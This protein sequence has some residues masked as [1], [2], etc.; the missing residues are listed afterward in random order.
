MVRELTLVEK[1]IAEAESSGASGQVEE[2][3][4][5]RATLLE[6]IGSS[7]YSTQTLKQLKNQLSALQSQLKAVEEQRNRRIGEYEQKKHLN[8]QTL[9][10]A[11]NNLGA[12]NKRLALYEQQVKEVR[13]IT[14]CHV[15]IAFTAQDLR[16]H[17]G[18]PAT[19]R[20]VRSQLQLLSV[21]GARSFRENGSVG[22]RAHCRG[23]QTVDQ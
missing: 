22:T 12:C 17:V 1:Q 9:V 6:R 19:G 20:C 8:D 7:V 23:L 3:R 13:L 5:K 11:V 18:E 16:L 21:L 2:L 4:K 10:S 14:A 15:A